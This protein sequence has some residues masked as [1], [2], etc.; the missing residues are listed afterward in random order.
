MPNTRP[1]LLALTLAVFACVEETPLGPP[2]SHV[3]G[4]VTSSTGNAEG[5][6]SDV[7][8]G[9]DDTDLPGCDPFGDPLAECG[10]GQE[11]DPSSLSCV[12]STGSGQPDTPCIDRD[13]CAP[14]L[15]CADGRCLSRCDASL[16]DPLPGSAGGC[17]SARVCALAEPPESGL[18]HERC[19]LLAQ[20]CSFDSDACNR[21]EV[22]EDSYAAACTSFGLGVTSDPC[23]DDR[24]CDAAS[25]CTP[26]STH[27]L[28]C[29]GAAAS[30]CTAICDPLSLPCIGVEPLC[31]P[32]DLG[33]QGTAG[34]CGVF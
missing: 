33:E 13:D 18:C 26:A 10:A 29:I 8:T 31:Q 23:E 4:P 25:L 30:C 15:G 16:V 5:S 9:G 32:L 3:T 34:Y 21:V 27:N 20:T 22:A 7:D 1:A 12:T 24:D 14:G 2:P 28:P 6:E 19:D 11:C 17:A